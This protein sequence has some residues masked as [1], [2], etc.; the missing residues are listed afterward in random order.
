M[1]LSKTESGRW[2]EDSFGKVKKK[3]KKNRASK[4]GAFEEELWARN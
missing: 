3:Q 2:T 1:G 4:K